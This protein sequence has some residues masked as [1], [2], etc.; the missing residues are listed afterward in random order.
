MVLLML[1]VIA[2]TVALFLVAFDVETCNSAVPFALACN[3]VVRFSAAIAVFG[4]L[5]AMVLKLSTILAR[6]QNYGVD[7]DKL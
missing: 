7:Y 4:V 6:I 5:I 2:V 3:A 1:V